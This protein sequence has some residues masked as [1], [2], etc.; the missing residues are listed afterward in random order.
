MRKRSIPFPRSICP[1]LALAA[2]T[3]LT[4]SLSFVAVDAAAAKP[5]GHKHSKGHKKGK[6]RKA[7]TPLSG[8][9]D[10]CSVSSPRGQDPLPS[11]AD[12]LTAL[13]QGGFRVVL[14]YGTADMSLEDNL[15]YANA[16]QAAGMQ[17]IWNLGT[18]RNLNTGGNVPIGPKL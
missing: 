11:C 16:A 15:T 7:A 1:L 3:V 13:R 12:R 8:I 2:A 10:S 6:A 5:H 9:Y 18:Y 4:L 17:V 14:N